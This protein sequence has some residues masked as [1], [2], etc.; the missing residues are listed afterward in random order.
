M[1]T[2]KGQVNLTIMIRDDDTMAETSTKISLF[3][4]NDAQAIARIGSAVLKVVREMIGV[5]SERQKE[6]GSRP[7][8]DGSNCEERQ[9]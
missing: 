2:L 3:K 7:G 1:E 6:V 9:S 4:L 5:P 8:E